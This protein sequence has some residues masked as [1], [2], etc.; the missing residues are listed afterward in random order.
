V[1]WLY[2]YLFLVPPTSSRNFTNL[3]IFW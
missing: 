1:L 3:I 2:F